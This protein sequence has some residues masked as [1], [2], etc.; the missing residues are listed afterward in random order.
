MRAH[1]VRCLGSIRD[2]NSSRK[3][4]VYLESLQRAGR[5]AFE[6]LEIKDVSRS[7]G[8]EWRGRNGALVKSKAW[9]FRI[10]VLAGRG[11]G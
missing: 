11:L 1:E 3:F 6:N 10:R 5:I 8:S 7:F 4:Q 2:G 9:L